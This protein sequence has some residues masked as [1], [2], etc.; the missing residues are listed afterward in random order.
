MS[1][2]LQEIPVSS[3]GTQVSILKGNDSQGY[4]GQVNGTWI[5]FQT[6]GEIVS[7]AVKQDYTLGA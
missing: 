4:S 5:V 1:N 6:Y 7:W 2:Q 3:G